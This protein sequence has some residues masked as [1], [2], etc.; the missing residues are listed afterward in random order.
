METYVEYKG[1]TYGKPMQNLRRACNQIAEQD[2]F[3]HTF[4]VGFW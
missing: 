3:L 2:I 1:I 4:T